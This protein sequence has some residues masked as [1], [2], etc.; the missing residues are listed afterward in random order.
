MHCWN[1]DVVLQM[2]DPFVASL[3]QLSLNP[4]DRDTH[5][6]VAYLSR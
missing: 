5:A 6:E 3:D 2:R 1:R 4:L